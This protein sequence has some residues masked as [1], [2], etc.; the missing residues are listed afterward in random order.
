MK[1]TDIKE[2]TDLFYAINLDKLTIQPINSPEDSPWGTYLTCHIYPN[3]DN[4]TII[5]IP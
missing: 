3:F 1:I 4:Y 2:A 5:T